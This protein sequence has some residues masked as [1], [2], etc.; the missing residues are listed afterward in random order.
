MKTMLNIKTQLRRIYHPKTARQVSGVLLDSGEDPW[1]TT[2]AGISYFCTVDRDKRG[3][4]VS[5]FEELS[6]LPE[7]ELKSIWPATQSELPPYKEIWA[8]ELQ[9]VDD[10]WYVYFAL[11]NG[12]PGEERMHVLEAMTDNPQG[13][14]VYKGKIA[15]ETD[16]WAIDGSVLTLPGSNE[17]YFVWSGWDGVMNEQQNIYIAAMADPCTLK[18]DRVCISKPEHTWEKQGYPYVNEGPQP[19]C[20]DQGDTFIIY[21]ASGSWTDDYCLGQLRLV[22]D[23]PLDPAAWAKHSQPV[24]KKTDTIF[25][26]GHCS[27]VK[28]KDG[29]DSIVY[30]TARA[31]G[32][33][34]DRQIRAQA[35]TWNA[36]GS[37]DF[38]KP[39]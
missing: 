8:P 20:N 30:H 26:P 38:G 6:E 9:R 7:S 2:Y 27:F 17:K 24:F 36:D 35:F 28:N 29:T 19:L 3:I 18:S 16:R 13:K 11:N 31:K 4:S 1:V 22:G 21:S 39:Q 10:K 37:P 32:S 15:A 12:D 5:K 33:G 14:Y 25:G 23:N 34:W